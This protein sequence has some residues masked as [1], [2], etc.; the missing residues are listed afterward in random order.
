MDFGWG[1]MNPWIIITKVPS[2]NLASK[3]A[4]KQKA[5]I[6][7]EKSAETQEEQKFCC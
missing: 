6:Y 2:K 7:S 3:L 1:Y 5:I 4:T